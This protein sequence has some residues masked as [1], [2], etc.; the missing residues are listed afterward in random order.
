MRRF[1]RTVLLLSLASSVASLFG[2]VVLM[3]ELVV[4]YI[5]DTRY[6]VEDPNRPDPARS[7]ASIF[8]FVW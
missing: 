5:L 8:R 3:D 1:P 6:K 2:Q 7:T 4:Q